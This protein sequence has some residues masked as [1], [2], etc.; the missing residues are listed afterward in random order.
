V[1]WHVAEDLRPP[2]PPLT[3]MRASAAVDTTADY[4]YEET[5]S[6]VPDKGPPSFPIDLRT[7]SREELLALPGIGPVL[8]DRIVAWRDTARSPLEVARLLEV[9]G[10]G[11]LTLERIVGMVTLSGVPPAGQR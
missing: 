3:L 8:V 4:L 1:L 5:G 11:P 7:A 10:I 2:P 6:Y 9:R